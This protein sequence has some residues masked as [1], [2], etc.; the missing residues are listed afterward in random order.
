MFLLEFETDVVERQSGRT[1]G[2]QV[3]N[4]KRKMEGKNDDPGKPVIRATQSWGDATKR[5][6]LRNFD[7]RQDCVQPDTKLR[8]NPSLPSGI[9]LKLELL[10]VLN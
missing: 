7:Q 4:D 1:M 8:R 6:E 5:V 10:N 9:R 3:C 2:L